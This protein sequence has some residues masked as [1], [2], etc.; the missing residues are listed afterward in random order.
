ML[1]A[2]LDAERPTDEERSHEVGRLTILLA[3]H[4][5]GGTLVRTCAPKT[6]S[7]ASA[8]SV[9]RPTEHSLVPGDHLLNGVLCFNEGTAGAAHALAQRTVR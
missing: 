8:G 1:V 7:S 4:L 2:A 6:C 3:T 5:P 9:G